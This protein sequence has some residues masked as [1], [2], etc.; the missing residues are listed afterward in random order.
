MFLIYNT[1]SLIQML[2]LK[3]ISSFNKQ[4]FNVLFVAFN[5]PVTSGGL[6]VIMNTISVQG[7]ISRIP[8]INAVWRKICPEWIH[9]SDQFRK[10]AMEFCVKAENDVEMVVLWRWLGDKGF[11]DLQP[12]DILDLMNSVL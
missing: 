10:P 8:P 4:A 3:V 7:Q 9:A 12:Y 5:N 11:E 1:T 2:D 6:N